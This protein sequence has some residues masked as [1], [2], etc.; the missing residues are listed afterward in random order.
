MQEREDRRAALG[1]WVQVEMNRDTQKR[2]QPFALEEIVAWLGHGFQPSQQAAPAA[3][4]EG[5][6]MQ[7]ALAFMQ[8]AGEAKA[9]GT[10][11]EMPLSG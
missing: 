3:P 7:K 9:N 11:G 10:S 8:L 4:A 5:D 1:A 6:L 2:M